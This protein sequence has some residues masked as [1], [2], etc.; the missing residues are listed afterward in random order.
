[1]RVLVGVGDRV[2]DGDGDLE[3]VREREGV[4]VVDGVLDGV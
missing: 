2:R 3:G 4:S 1:M